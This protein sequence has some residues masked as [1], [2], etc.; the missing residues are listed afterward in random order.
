[1]ER[2]CPEEHLNLSKS[3]FVSKEDHSGCKSHNIAIRALKGSFLCQ[4]WYK[5]TYKANLVNWRGSSKNKFACNNHNFMRLPAARW[6]DSMPPQTEI[7]NFFLTS[8]IDFLFIFGQCGNNCK[9][10]LQY[11]ETNQVIHSQFLCV[12]VDSGCTLVNYHVIEISRS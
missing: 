2:T 10:N 12:I 11:L 7:L 9:Y 1:M 4:I 5:W 6:K 3:G 8:H